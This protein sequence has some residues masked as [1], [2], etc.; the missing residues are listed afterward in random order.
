MIWFVWL[1]G[2]IFFLHVKKHNVRNS[3]FLLSFVMPPGWISLKSFSLSHII[4]QCMYFCIARAIL[5]VEGYWCGWRPC[6]FVHQVDFV[7]LMLFHY[8]KQIMRMV[9]RLSFV[10]K[11]WCFTTTLYVIILYGKVGK[12]RIFSTHCS[13]WKIKKNFSSL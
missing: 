7:S 4:F 1:L 9:W 5:C 13:V 12:N 6:T 11:D 2:L 10:I 3:I 8:F